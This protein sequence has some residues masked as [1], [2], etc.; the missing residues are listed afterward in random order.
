[1]SLN[2]VIELEALRCAHA[3]ELLS[4]YRWMNF[5]C[6]QYW[7]CINDRIVVR[8]CGCLRVRVRRPRTMKGDFG[9]KPGFKLGNDKIEPL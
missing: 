7:C 2:V 3:A 5:A 4:V 1:M 6:A 8:V 9:F